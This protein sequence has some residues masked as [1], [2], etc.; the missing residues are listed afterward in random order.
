MAFQKK[1][2][3][4]ALDKTKLR[5]AGLKSISPT[6]DLGND[7]SV[8][9][10]AAAIK[11]IDD[12]MSAYNTKLSEADDLADEFDRTEKAAMDLTERALD[13]VGVKYGKDSDEFMQAGGTKKSERKRPAP[14]APTPTP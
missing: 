14:K 5:L 12:S 4:L 6:L 13:A 11:A 7:I 10:M 2:S 9:T 8:V 3:S 1:T